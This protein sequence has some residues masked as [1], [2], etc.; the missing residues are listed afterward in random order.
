MRE[1][2][3]STTKP[4][5]SRLRRHPARKRSWSILEHKTHRLHTNCVLIYSRAQHND[6]V[7]TAWRI[8]IVE[9]AWL[10][11]RWVDALTHRHLHSIRQSELAFWVRTSHATALQHTDKQF[12]HDTPSPEKKTK[13]F[14][15]ISSIKHGPSQFNLVRSFRNKFAA[16]SCK[17]FPPHLNNVSTLPCE[18]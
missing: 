15:V 5:F 7:Q 18:S 13:M 6:D 2:S 9:Q 1:K 12:T 8:L 3:T 17:R 4:W 16:K 11:D 14:F 10:A